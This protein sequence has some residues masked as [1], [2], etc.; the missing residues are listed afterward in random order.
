[1]CN[2]YGIF[3]DDVLFAVMNDKYIYVNVNIESETKIDRYFNFRVKINARKYHKKSLIEDLN[4]L[5]FQRENL[6]KWLELDDGSP[7]DYE[8]SKEVIQQ[9]KDID[10]SIKALMELSK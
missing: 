7:E 6:F 3:E 2:L 9:I 5:N 8:K 4:L 10:A 1:M